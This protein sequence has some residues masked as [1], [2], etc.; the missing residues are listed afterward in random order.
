M[1]DAIDMPFRKFIRH[2]TL[3]LQ[4]NRGTIINYCSNSSKISNKNNNDFR[5]YVD[6]PLPPTWIWDILD[7]YVYQFY[8]C[9]RWRKSLKQEE[10]IQIKGVTSFWNL[11]EVVE[12]LEHFYSQRKANPSTMVDILAHYSYLAM[13]KIHVMGAH[14]QDALKMIDQI[15]YDDLMVFSKAGG[16]YQ[17]LF[18]FAGFSYLMTRQYRKA[19]LTLSLIVNYFHKHKQLY[20]KS[21]QYEGLI[22]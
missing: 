9:S 22:K 4:L 1:R 10:L 3:R 5:A 20:T 8:L 19:H 7:E 15:T 11:Q 21:F 6:I 17:S 13:I 14:Y 12:T 16:A 18:S 2:S